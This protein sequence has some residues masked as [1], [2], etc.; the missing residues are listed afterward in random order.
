M[1]KT[2][3]QESDLDLVNRMNIADRDRFRAELDW[4]YSQVIIAPADARDK[5]TPFG[6]RIVGLRNAPATNS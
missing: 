1:R 4:V 6:K 3:T 5:K 2:D